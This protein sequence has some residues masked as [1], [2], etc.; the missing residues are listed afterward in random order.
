MNRIEGRTDAGC[1]D[2]L[3]SAKKFKSVH[4]T[5]G[6]GDGTAVDDPPIAAA[7]GGVGG[8]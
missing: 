3:P 2:G 6:E 7:G 4:S 5:D 8:A 1:D